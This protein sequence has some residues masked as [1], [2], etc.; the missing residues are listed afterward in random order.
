MKRITSILVV[1][2][3]TMVAVELQT[4]PTTPVQISM[5]RPL[6]AGYVLKQIP[7]SAVHHQ[8]VGSPRIRLRESTSGNWSG[9]AVPLETSGVS[10]TF[11]A[12]QGTWTVP[13]VTGSRSATY[14]SAW[15]GL[16]R[17]ALDVKQSDVFNLGSGDGYSVRQVIESARKVTG[18]PIPVIENP[19]RPGDPPK[20]VGD[21]TKIRKQLGW[22][23]RYDSID[24]IVESAWLWHK[25]HPQGYA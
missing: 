3:L 4:D 17:L 12:V 22:K 8:Q 5:S 7:F 11:S 6:Q 15:V 21:S 10:D 13:T 19:R 16:D 23:P 20:L 24:A 14:S 9:Y 25:A 1:A 2:V 18:H